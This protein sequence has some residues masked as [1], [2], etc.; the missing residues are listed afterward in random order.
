LGAKRRW[1]TG[2]RLPK[3]EK[4]KNRNKKM[5]A[6]AQRF[7]IAEACGWKFSCEQNEDA[8]VFAGWYHPTIRGNLPDY[9]HDMDAM[10]EAE[11][12][13][14]MGTQFEADYLKGCVSGGTAAER[15]ERFLR[16][17]GKWTESDVPII[18]SP[19]KSQPVP[20]DAQSRQAELSFLRAEWAIA[21]QRAT[22]LQKAIEVLVDPRLEEETAIK[23][24][25]QIARAPLGP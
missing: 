20:L 21:Q 7:A 6:Q 18:L 4:L 11:M 25:R 14:L 8:G 5:N 23:V 24:A 19:F 3:P 12:A 2:Q 17:I 22:Q 9:L 15:A 10:H 13:C 1:Q 16:I